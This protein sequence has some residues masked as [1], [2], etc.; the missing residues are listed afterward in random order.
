LFV[1]LGDEQRDLKFLR[2]QLLGLVCLPL[3]QRLAAR[4]QLCA[5]PLDPRPRRELVEG[6][7]RARPC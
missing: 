1:F 4:P 6:L 3:L 5:R 2:G 7:Q